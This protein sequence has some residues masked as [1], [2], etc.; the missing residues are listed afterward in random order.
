MLLRR[1][2]TP[3]DGARGHVVYE[4]MMP[5]I[6]PLLFPLHK[7]CDLGPFQRSVCVPKGAR[8]VLLSL[9]RFHALRVAERVS[10]LDLGADLRLIGLAQPHVVLEMG[11]KVMDVCTGGLEHPPQSENGGDNFTIAIGN[12]PADD[13]AKLRAAAIVIATCSKLT[14]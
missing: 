8:A 11:R 14:W 5:R 9:R 2:F 3:V 4:V 10:L 6:K 12:Q 1:R 13:I 7:E